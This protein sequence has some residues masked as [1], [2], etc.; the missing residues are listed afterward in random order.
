[1]IVT[2]T[3]L[4]LATK[5]EKE[6]GSKKVLGKEVLSVSTD[7][8]FWLKLAYPAAVDVTKSLLLLEIVFDSNLVRNDDPFPLVANFAFFHLVCGTKKNFIIRAVVHIRG[9]QDKNVVIEVV[10][11]G[12]TRLI[13]VHFY[14][15]S[16]AFFYLFAWSIII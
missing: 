13:S 4:K 7:Q 14:A 1:M 3:N 11:F 10:L 16:S 5:A 2:E 8:N 9:I 15:V 12:I 6:S